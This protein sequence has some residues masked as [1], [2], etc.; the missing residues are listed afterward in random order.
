MTSYV[1]VCVLFTYGIVFLFLS[2]TYLHYWHVQL[3]FV[4]VM[5]VNKF[6]DWLLGIKPWFLGC[7]AWSLVAIPSELSELQTHNILF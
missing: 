4:T 5:D 3:Y 7:P 6:I 1:P 2:Y